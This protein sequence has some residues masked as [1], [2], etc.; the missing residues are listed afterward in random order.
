MRRSSSLYLLLIL[1]L[2]LLPAVSRSATL[3]TIHP[4]S[5]EQAGAASGTS[6]HVVQKIDS[7]VKQVLILSSLQP[8]LPVPDLIVNG[9]M[10]TFTKRGVSVSDIFTEYL[11]LDR[12]QDSE[13]RSRAATLLE[14]KLS[15]RRV[16]LII[17]IDQPA[18]EFLAADGENIF[19]G[20]P[21][22]T[23][24]VQKP[25]VV[26]KGKPR[27][28]VDTFFKMDVAGTLRLATD[29][30]PKTRRLVVINGNGDSIVPFL[31]VTAKALGSLPQRLQVEHTGRLTYEQML[32]HVATLPPGT[33]AFLGAYFSDRTGRHFIP[34]EV[35]AAVAKAANVPVFAQIDVH[36]AKGLLGG[37]VAISSEIG[38]R[39]A[40][41]ALD[42]L[43]GNLTLTRQMTRFEINNV[44]VFN[45]QQLE[46]WGIGSR[47]LPANATFINRPPT[48]W[49]QYQPAV[50]TAFVAF[51][52]LTVFI[53][54]LMVQNRHRKIAERKAR[55]SESRFRQLIEQAP[56]AILLYDVDRDLFVEANPSAEALFGFGRAE[57][58]QSRPQNFY[59]SEQPDQVAVNESFSKHTEQVMSGEQVQFERAIRSADGRDLICEVRLARILFAD[60][61]L[62][63]ASYLDITK[64][65]QLEANLYL[66]TI[67]LQEELGERQIA[68]EALQEQTAILEEEIEERSRAEEALI[69]SENK[70]RLLLDS[71]GEAI[72]GI[73]VQ[74]N[75]TFCN[76]ACLKVLGYPHSD[77]LVGKNM[78][79]LI[80]HCYANGTPFPVENS[81]IGQTCTLGVSSH[82]DQEVLWKADS[83][84]FAAEYWSYPQYDK[85]GELVGAVVTF[86]DISE[87]KYLAEQLR[88]AQKMEAVGQLAGGIAHDFNNILQVISGYG[89]ILKMNAEL[90]ADADAAVETIISSAEKAAQLTHGLLAFSRKQVMVLSAI[91]LNDIVQNVN[92]FLGRVIGEDIH[93]KTKTCEGELTIYSEA[94]QV[95]QILVNL[96]TN[97]RDAMQKGG[98]LVLE[99]GLQV[100]ETP[101]NFESGRAEPGRYAVITVSDTGAGMD[102]KTRKKIF[103]PFFTTKEVGKGTGLGMSIV[104]GIVNQHNGFINVYSE[105][106]HGTT[107]RIYLPLY[108]TCAPDQRVRA[109]KPAV[110]RGGT[111]AILLAEDDADVRK[112][113]VTVLTRFG[114]QVIQAV[115]GQDAV[116][117]FDANKDRILMILMDMIMP[118][119][120]G[121]EAYED[122]CRIQPGVKVL[123]SSGYTADFIENRGVSED[124]IELI[125]K[126]VQ[127]LELLRK[128]REMLDSPSAIS[129]AR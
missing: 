29:L 90:D 107:F 37:S 100:L 129:T 91:D 49:G 114:Y 98:S 80:H 103:E 60:R 110:P 105:V 14:H 55:E 25:E 52:V 32:Q 101:M 41:I 128:V 102:A 47:R 11:D 83:S 50:I 97:S 109:V 94:G 75:C 13:Y 4:P 46:R 120:N 53:V 20:V 76:T 39:A 56:D 68:Q 17:V 66:Q 38:K 122:I 81:L 21:V 12:N 73:D 57:L 72:Y 74:G 118:R 82:S 108:E 65:K 124:G 5:E 54:A 7:H 119:K 9:I 31:E 42:Y 99:T 35:A 69:E 61:R 95:E 96:A 24:Y 3:R 125:M 22:L 40:E 92:K 127:P 16:D 8:G 59:K 79:D 77:D 111:E 126:P 44:P 18:L 45:W 84:S 6:L 33:I 15:P 112:L 62:I 43:Q 26:W 71:T 121:K 51:L 63:R 85:A 117:K 2:I 36:V 48:L 116:E 113:V 93:L 58:L 123:Y 70:L 88:Q 104:Y 1:F 115:D 78:H 34:A 27:Q 86:I 67:Q 87:R 10:D 23:V 106:G 19:P 64:R 89:H 28:V 30:F